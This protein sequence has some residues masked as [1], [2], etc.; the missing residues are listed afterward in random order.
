MDRA[1]PSSSEHHEQPV[2]TRQKLLALGERL[3]P[4]WLKR[5]PIDVP[6]EGF[7]RGFVAVGI[8]VFAGLIGYLIYQSFGTVVSDYANYLIQLA[9]GE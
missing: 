8:L 4:Q 5:R 9:G 7:A 6:K 1:K 3:R 2:S